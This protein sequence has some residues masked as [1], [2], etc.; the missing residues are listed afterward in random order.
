MKQPNTQHSTPNT[1]P[2][3]DVAQKQDFL[4]LHGRRIG[5]ITNQTGLNRAG[6]PT[7]VLLRHA[8]GVLLHT[9]FSPEHGLRGMVD[10]AVPDALD[11]DVGLPVFSL[12]GERRQP[13]T[14]QLQ[15]LD[16]LVFDIQDIGT[17]YYTYISTLGLCM[18]AAAKHHLHFIAL[19]R[20]NPIGGIAA[21]GP[22]PDRLG[23]TAYHSLPVRHGLTVGELA[24]LFN[25]EKKLKLDLEVIPITGWK[26]G[27]L[28]DATG[29]KWT[30]PSPNMRSPLAALLYPGIGLLE[31]SNLSVGRG[32]ASP[33]E[34]VGADWIDGANLAHALNA[35]MIP[36]VHFTDLRFTPTSS[37]YAG[38]SCGGVRIAL[39]DTALFVPTFAGI[40]FAEVLRKLYP[41][42]WEAAKLNDLLFHAASVKALLRGATAEE[43]VHRWSPD[44]A[45]FRERC[46]PFL[47]YPE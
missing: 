34:L 41:N 47:L 46:K 39:T 38:K 4:P 23:F 26:R 24:R 29:L 9:L 30:N 8:P 17:R 18:E 5:L 2:G 44:T 40:A 27:D 22:L 14:A 11:S 43:I 32:T 16:T 20:P 37:D 1:L 12:Y 28:W 10:A 25:A 45:R 15:D 13:T 35:R 3:I 33:F 6:K 31:G 36:G 21:E 19:D 42:A 7:P